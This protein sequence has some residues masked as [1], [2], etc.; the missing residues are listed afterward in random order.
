MGLLA[1]RFSRQC[2]A[3]AMSLSRVCQSSYQRSSTST[4]FPSPFLP[5]NFEIILHE[6]W[7][8]N[9]LVRSSIWLA[10]ESDGNVEG[11]AFVQRPAANDTLQHGLLNPFISS[12]LS[13][14]IPR[15][16]PC[17]PPY[18]LLLRQIQESQSF[19]LFSRTNR[20]SRVC[21]DRGCGSIQ[22]R[23]HV[24]VLGGLSCC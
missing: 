21:Y 2:S 24:A 18:S 3:R 14:A 13:T 11:T 9:E 5:V 16:L 6:F 10:V 23:P 4:Y 8:S 17:C 15:S 7:I 19:Y 22:S 12:S 1:Y 20:F